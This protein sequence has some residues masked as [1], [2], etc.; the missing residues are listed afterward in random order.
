MNK[1]III[2]GLEIFF[3]NA[4]SL[5]DARNHA[6]NVCNHSKEILVTVDGS[7]ITGGSGTYVKLTETPK[8]GDIIYIENYL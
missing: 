3:F 1:Y 5:A 2:N 4:N 8:N 7:A 6:I